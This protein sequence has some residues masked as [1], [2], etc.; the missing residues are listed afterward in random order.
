MSSSSSSSSSSSKSKPILRGILFDVEETLLHHNK[1]QQQ[2]VPGAFEVGRWLAA[3]DIPTAL[4]TSSNTSEST[5][6][7]MMRSWRDT[8]ITKVVG[9]DDGVDDGDG[10]YS[11]EG[12]EGFHPMIVQDGYTPNI[13][14]AW[15]VSVG[16]GVPDELLMVLADA[17]AEDTKGDIPT[18]LIRRRQPSS[19]P[20]DEPPTTTSNNLQMVITADNLIDLP[21][22]IWNTYTI[23]SKL[24]TNHL[25]PEKLPPPKPLTSIDKAAIR[26]DVLFLQ[27]IS[28]EELH[29]ANWNVDENI[30]TPLIWAVEYG[31]LDVVRYLLQLSPNAVT[32]M[33]NHRGFLGCTAVSRA[34]RRNHMGGGIRSVGRRTLFPATGTPQIPPR[35]DEDD[36]SSGVFGLYGGITRRTSESHLDT[37]II[38][39]VVLGGGGGADPDIP[40]YKMQY[41][42]HIAA[43]HGNRE[44]VQVLIDGGGGEEE[45]E[46]A[47]GLGANVNV[48]D[49]RDDD[50]GG[51]EE[52]EEAGG[53]GANVNVL[54]RKGRRPD[55]DTGDDAIQAMIADAREA[56][57]A[58]P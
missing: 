18:A 43:F 28:T 23:Q 25:R 49:G 14:K 4:I 48:L 13:A 39:A 29:T 58:L 37:P 9:E 47:G 33:T 17:D 2:L 11:G 50:R 41:P 54:D 5:T 15:G 6:M 53:L 22:Q 34:A 21:H 32:K 46:E 20:S 31:Q 26:G 1:E 3:H 24:L 45:E 7:E 55:G 35:G 30:N 36:E 10:Q 38:T 44:A 42:L 40:N 51:E 12:S 52:E 8:W 19:S 16:S 56:L 27:S 57:A